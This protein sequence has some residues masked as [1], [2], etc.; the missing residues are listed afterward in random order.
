MC[1]CVFVAVIDILAGMDRGSCD[2]TVVKALILPALF[3][4]FKHPIHS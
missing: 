4:I 3:L 2:G 1:M